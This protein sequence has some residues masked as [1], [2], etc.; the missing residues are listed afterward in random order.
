MTDER[1][2]HDPALDTA[3]RAHVRDEPPAALDQSVLAAAHRAVQSTPRPTERPARPRWR[4]WTPLAVA[5]TL[6]VI[7]FGVVELLP[8][9]AA[10]DNAAVVSDVPDVPLR[11]DGAPAPPAASDAT[12]ALQAERG[13]AANAEPGRGS[14]SA[15]QVQ[16]RREASAPSR[17][18]NEAATPLKQRRE[19]AVA[20]SQ[21]FAGAP[22][23]AKLAAPSASE[24]KSAPV[25]APPPPPP[26]PAPM[27]REQPAP[28][29]GAV[30]RTPDDFI[31]EIDRLRAAGRD[32]DAALAL[33]AF[34]AAYDD[35]DA[36]LPA[37]LRDWARGVPRP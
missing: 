25:A 9:Q 12:P 32:A 20:E 5:A 13:H 16:Q 10:D 17:Q 11:K 35:A 26:S 22:G 6:G 14:D 30:A 27:M 29:T 34:R 21:P 23:R 36:R 28:S 18:R 3:W 15:A 31:R 2:L 37:S 24:D 33:S 7:A 4:A 1:D 19:G 8:R